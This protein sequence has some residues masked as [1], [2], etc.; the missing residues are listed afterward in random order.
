MPTAVHEPS[1][2]DRPSYL[3][4]TWGALQKG[5]SSNP[6]LLLAYMCFC[7]NYKKAFL[8]CPWAEIGSSPAPHPASTLC[9]GQSSRNKGKAVFKPPHLPYCIS[10]CSVQNTWH[11]WQHFLNLSFTIFLTQNLFWSLLQ[12][13][14]HNSTLTASQIDFLETKESSPLGSTHAIA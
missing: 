11:I 3:N 7:L 8:L 13:K 5:L 4:K 6:G 1:T 2:L 9:Q 12:S 10:L 14:S